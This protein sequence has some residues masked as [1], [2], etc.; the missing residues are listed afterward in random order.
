MKN[1]KVFDIDGK[2]IN[3]E[4]EFAFFC[5]E[6]GKNYVALNNKNSVF[7]KTSKFINIDILEIKEQKNKYIYLT[8]IP[9]NE[10]NIV[11]KSLQNNIFSKY[12]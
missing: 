11:K 12:N 6:T 3:I 10:W 8:N 7:E 2:Q 5:K 4:I 9:D 1:I